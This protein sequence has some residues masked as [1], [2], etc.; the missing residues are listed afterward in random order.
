M[1][2]LYYNNKLINTNGAVD[3]DVI[4]QL[5]DRPFVFKIIEDTSGRIHKERIPV[6]E[7]KIVKTY[8]F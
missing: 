6:S 8:V 2:N 3:D 5:K 7:I 1:Y 4:K